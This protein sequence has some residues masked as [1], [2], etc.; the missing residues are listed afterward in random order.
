MSFK[1]KFVSSFLKWGIYL[2]YPEVLG[3]SIHIHFKHYNNFHTSAVRNVYL[4]FYKL[5]TNIY[6]NC[7]KF[8]YQKIAKIDNTKL[9]SHFENG[10]DVITHLYKQ[11]SIST[12]LFCSPALIFLQPDNSVRISVLSKYKMRVDIMSILKVG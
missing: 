8:H 3:P 5:V 6:S 10:R 2:Q 12:T 1:F 11:A 9:L 4:T 7:L